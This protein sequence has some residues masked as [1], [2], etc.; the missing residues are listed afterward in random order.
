MNCVLTARIIMIALIAL[1][2]LIA[3]I[4]TII[5]ITSIPIWLIVPRKRHR[6]R[7]WNCRLACGLI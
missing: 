5:L 1:I 2:V 6:I 3:L 7:T 4:A